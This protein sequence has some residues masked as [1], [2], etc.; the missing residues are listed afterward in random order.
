MPVA[1]KIREDPIHS[2]NRKIS[3]LQCKL[4]YIQKELCAF[5][6]NKKTKKARL[7]TLRRRGGRSFWRGSNG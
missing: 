2:I 4:E 1:Y 3:L 6:A 5:S 7:A